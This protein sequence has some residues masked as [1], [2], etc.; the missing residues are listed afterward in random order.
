MAPRRKVAE[1]GTDSGYYRHTRTLGEKACEACF[2]A[3]Q[4]ANRKRDRSKRARKKR[5]KCGRRIQS[6]NYSVC[7]SCRADA[8]RAGMVAADITWVKTST[9]VWR[10]VSVFDPEPDAAP[11]R[12]A[13]GA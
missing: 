10:A 6:V 12:K 8:K 2:T 7:R 9:G 4:E 5:C 1:C 13:V 3:H 11:P